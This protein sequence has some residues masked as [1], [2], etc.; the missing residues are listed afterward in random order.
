M[1]TLFLM[2]CMNCG[3]ACAYNIDGLCETCTEG[4]DDIY[5]PIYNTIL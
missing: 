2:G 5:N 3:E 4:F 1:S